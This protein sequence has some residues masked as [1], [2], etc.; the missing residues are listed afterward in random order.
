MD[1]FGID[2][3]HIAYVLH[4]RPLIMDWLVVSNM[5]DKFYIFLVVTVTMTFNTCVTY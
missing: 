3:C 4:T 1:V 5:Q 2:L